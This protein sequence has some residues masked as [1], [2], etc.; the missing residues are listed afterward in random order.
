MSKR[1]IQRELRELLKKGD[2]RGIVALSKSQ[3]SV[4][5]ILISMTYG[6]HSLTSWRAMEAIGNITARMPEPKVRTLIQRLLWMMREE[7][8]TNPWSAGQ[9]ISE[10]LRS[11]PSSFEDIVPIII[12]FHD[13]KILRTG[14]LWC[15]YRVGAVRPDLVAPFVKV[16]LHYL[17]SDDPEDRGYALLAL[18]GMGG[19][20]HLPAVEERVEDNAT[21][22]YYDGRAMVET[23]IMDLARETAES[24]RN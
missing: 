24:L 2:F 19:S 22:I 8:G 6:K 13:E 21:F 18:K 7:S 1:E 10:I 17:R 12:T 3:S 9:I 5:R 4:A 20:E 11:N 23:R 14:S 15:M 16:A